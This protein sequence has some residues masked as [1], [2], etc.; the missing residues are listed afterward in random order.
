MVSGDE[1]VAG[2]RSIFWSLRY[3]SLHATAEI[4]SHEA[5][6]LS[7]ETTPQSEKSEHH[8]GSQKPGD[9]R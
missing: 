4:L 9:K 2:G 6:Q 7:D 1:V 5:L 3:E 8:E